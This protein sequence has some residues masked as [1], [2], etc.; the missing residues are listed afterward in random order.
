MCT[1]KDK[2]TNCAEGCWYSK[3]DFDPVKSHAV[4]AT[5][6]TK[7]REESLSDKCMFK[8]MRAKTG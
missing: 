8:S 5:R 6:E 4:L 3:N 7:L 1:F 2:P